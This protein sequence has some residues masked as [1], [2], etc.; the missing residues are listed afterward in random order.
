MN[1]VHS[2]GLP[3]RSTRG[4]FRTPDEPAGSTCGAVA[5]VGPLFLLLGVP[6]AVLV[7]AGAAAGARAGLAVWAAARAAA[8]A[9]EGV[10]IAAIGDALAAGFS[11][12]GCTL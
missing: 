12:D 2:M 5:G 11:R 3:G 1:S 8:G 9:V 10:A 4:T 7:A 6:V